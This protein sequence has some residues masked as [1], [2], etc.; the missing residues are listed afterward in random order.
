MIDAERLEY[1]D[2]SLKR[3]KFLE[4]LRIPRLWTFRGTKI[5]DLYQNRWVY[6]KVVR[7][8][9]SDRLYIPYIHREGLPRVPKDFRLLETLADPP[10]Y[11]SANTFERLKD[12]KATFVITDWNNVVIILNKGNSFVKLS[13]V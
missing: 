3:I 5:K 9:P 12:Q 7:V 6:K 11:K 8:I 2:V 4:R 1:L 10:F 13:L